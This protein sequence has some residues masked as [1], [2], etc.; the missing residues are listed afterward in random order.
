[1]FNINPDAG[2]E[3]NL[4]DIDSRISLS[5]EIEGHNNKIK[6]GVSEKNQPVYIHIYGDYNVIEIGDNANLYGLR[7]EI[8]SKR[9]KSNNCNLEIGSNFSIASKGR[10][11]LPNCGNK[12]VIGNRCMFSNTV[13]IRGG[14]YPHLIFDMVDKTYLDVSDGIFIGNH[15]WVGEGAYINKSVSI[16]NECIVGGRSVVT[17][18]FTSENVVI[19]GSPARVVKENIQWFA[20]KKELVKG[21]GYFEAFDGVN[22]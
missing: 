9:H 7:I 12:L 20:N 3:N 15:V 2:F 19:A 13:T 6:I 11:L 10:F 5:G 1:M 22:D 4:I 16:G 14:E 18:R 8:G 21:D 17:K